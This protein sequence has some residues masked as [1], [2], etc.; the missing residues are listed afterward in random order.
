MNRREI[1]GPKSTLLDQTGIE[2]IELDQN[3]PEWTEED[4]IRLKRIKLDKRDQTRP[5]GPKW[6]EM[7]R[8][9]SSIKIQ[10]TVSL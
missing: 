2:Q 10:Q 4:R 6:P 9:T 7:D 3:W 1:N 8:T 5:K